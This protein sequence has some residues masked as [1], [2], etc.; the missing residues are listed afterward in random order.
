MLNI[1][2]RCM[3]VCTCEVFTYHSISRH[4]LGSFIHCLP[5]LGLTFLITK[6]STRHPLQ[7]PFCPLYFLFLNI[8]HFICNHIYIFFPKITQGICHQFIFFKFVQKHSL[9]KNMY[10]RSCSAFS[11]FSVKFCTNV[12]NWKE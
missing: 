9:K 3:V 12:K 2:Q 8:F 5:F 1:G 4:L 6:L 11:F 7:H 10:K